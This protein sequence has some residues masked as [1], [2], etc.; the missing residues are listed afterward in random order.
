M[1]L[2]ARLAVDSTEQGRGVGA[3]LLKDA[4]LR[5]IQAPEI[6]RL[7][8]MLVH[9]K[10]GFEPSPIDAYYLFLSLSDILSSLP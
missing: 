6:A 7:R 4:Q 1:I 5:T 2:L 9:A 10:F 8:A 3:G